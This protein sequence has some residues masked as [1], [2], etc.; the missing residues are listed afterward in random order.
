MRRALDDRTNSCNWCET[1]RSG[2]SGRCRCGARP[3]NRNSSSDD[4]ES[5]EHLNL[6]FQLNLTDSEDSGSAFSDVR[7]AGQTDVT[8]STGSWEEGRVSATQES[9]MYELGGPPPNGLLDTDDINSIAS[10]VASEEE[11]RLSRERRRAAR[12]V[13]VSDRAVKSAIS[14]LS[15]KIILRYVDTSGSSSSAASFCEVRQC[16][17]KSM[18]HC[19]AQASDGCEGYCG[20][21]YADLVRTGLLCPTEK[22]ANKVRKSLAKRKLGSGDAEPTQT[23]RWKS[24]DVRPKES[25]RGHRSVSG[26]AKRGQSSKNT[27]RPRHRDDDVIESSEEN[28]VAHRRARSARGA[29]RCI[30]PMCDATLR[31]DEGDL[32]RKCLKTLDAERHRKKA[33]AKALNREVRQAREARREQAIP[34]PRHRPPYA[35]SRHGHDPPMTS[36][37]RRSSS[38]RWNRRAI[39]ADVASDTDDFTWREEAP[40]SLVTECS[41][42]QFR[43]IS[44][45]GFDT[46][47]E[48][49]ECRRCNAVAVE[50]GLCEAC[51]HERL[52]QH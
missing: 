7:A 36:A 3:Q 6:N 49:E 48:V 47:P 28:N 14:H 5:Q 43:P 11:R 20:E 35:H 52:R 25:G 24:E 2:A 4:N 27:S 33:E 32:C 30:A 29:R 13:T 1:H 18:P 15:N 23:P 46:P 8:E 51:H 34:S 40:S 21:H 22:L 44:D 37:A 41:S 31:S 17:F 45:S 39:V 50:S 19:K 12:N 26:R 16:K 9:G 38:T 42:R 10:G